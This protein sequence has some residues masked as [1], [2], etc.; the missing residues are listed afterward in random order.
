MYAGALDI[1]DLKNLVRQRA[2][3]LDVISTRPF[4]SAGSYGR[5]PYFEI[6]SGSLARDQSDLFKSYTAAVTQSYPE[7]YHVVLR[8]ASVVGQGA[9]VTPSGRLIRDSSVEFL[10]HNLTPEGLIRDAD[11]FRMRSSTARRVDRPTLLLQRPWYL[12]Y[13]HWLVD[14]ASLLACVHML[15]LPDDWQIMVGAQSSMPLRKIV[16]QSTALLVPGIGLVERPIEETWTFAELHY[17]SPVHVPALF[18]LPYALTSLRAILGRKTAH[19]TSGKQRLFVTRGGQSTRNLTNEEEVVDF[20]LTRGFVSFDTTGKTLVEQIAAFQ[21]ADVVVG[22]KGAAL[23]NIL[24]SRPGSHLVVLSPGD[25]PDPF[26]WD[27]A[28]QI[29]INY[30]EIFGLIEDNSFP[31]SHNPF[32]IVVSD[33][34][35][36]LDQVEIN[37]IGQG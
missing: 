31:Q 26:F 5:L 30:S 10:A 36:V 34:A 33:L 9:V 14:S 4:F 35:E 12:N 22:V 28:A 17:L 8:D 3:T 11:G 29:S 19:S 24:F 15:D 32:S 16:M 1:V 18:K 21:A 6:R 2:E 37:L 13:G 27:L 25:F 20:L 7:G 23:T